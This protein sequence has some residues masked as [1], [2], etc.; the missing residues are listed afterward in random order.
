MLHKR[1]RRLV[2]TVLT[3][4]MLGNGLQAQNFSC[5]IGTRGACLDYGDTICS[6]SGQCVDQNAECFDRYQCDFEG[7]TCKSNVTECASQYDDLARR[8]NELVD[9]FDEMQKAAKRI[10]ENYDYVNL[11]VNAADDLESAQRCILW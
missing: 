9:E 11:C 3:A 4:A 8:H 2:I 5:R 10:G 7:F 6:S 1:A